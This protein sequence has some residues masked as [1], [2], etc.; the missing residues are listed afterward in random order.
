ML[1]GGIIGGTLGY[2]LQYYVTVIYFPHQY[3][4]AAAA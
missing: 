4:R 2:L 3:R 1:I